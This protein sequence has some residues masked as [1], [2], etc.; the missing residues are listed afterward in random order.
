MYI[1]KAAVIGAGAMGAEIA[2]VISYSG[3]P[4]LLKDVDQAMLDKGM[5]RI[6]KIYQGRVD[7]GKMSA[8]EV[9]AKLGL[10]TPVLGYEE[11][12][13]VDIVIEAVP[14]K[15]SVKRA[16]LSE[17]ARALPE[18]AIVASNTSALSISEMGAASGRPGKM[19]GMHFFNPAHVMKLVE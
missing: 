7:K 3:L 1:F 2:Q 16:V 13:D 17:L 11:F 15:M 5:A 19:I 6:R 12:G 18:S 4:V 8:G 9:E 10:I 14:E